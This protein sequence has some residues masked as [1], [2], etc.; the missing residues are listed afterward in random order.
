MLPNPTITST[1]NRISPPVYIASSCRTRTAHSFVASR[2]EAQS[3]VTELETV[4]AKPHGIRQISRQAGGSENRAQETS[5]LSIPDAVA[6]DIPADN[7]RA[8][9]AVDLNGETGAI[10]RLDKIDG[11]WNKTH[12]CGG[13]VKAPE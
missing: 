11:Q 1:S 5:A 6:R 8:W 3:L 9:V 12:R 7:Q 2:T 13:W 4:S 10:M